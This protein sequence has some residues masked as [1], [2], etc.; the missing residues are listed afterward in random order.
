MLKIGDASTVRPRRGHGWV[1]GVALATVLA[2]SNGC[3]GSE[4]SM[5]TVGTST[6][7]AKPVL[8]LPPST[9][10]VSVAP[11]TQEPA[12][13]PTS[14]A[15]PGSLI[16]SDTAVAVDGCLGLWHTVQSS[17]VASGFV[18]ASEN[19][20]VQVACENASDLLEAD[21]SDAPIGS[22]PSRQ[23]AAVVTNISLLAVAHTF[24]FLPGAGS[25]GEQPS[26][27]LSEESRANFFVLPPSAVPAAFQGQPALP[28]TVHDIEGLV[29]DG[30]ATP[31]TTTSVPAPAA[32]DDLSA[33]LDLATAEGIL[34][35]LVQQGLPIGEQVVYTEETDP[36]ERLGRPGSYVGKA[37]WLDVRAQDGCL[38]DEIG[39]DCGGDVEVFDDQ[40]ALDDRFVYL[41]GFANESVVGGYYMW[42]VENAIVRVGFALTPTEASDY[43]RALTSLFGSAEQYGV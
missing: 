33:A 18:V 24:R 3:S 26:C 19:A 30:E 15:P 40:A 9:T 12:V 29:V 39:W 5:E 7:A 25:C 23:L 41:S 43:D 8:T 16:R 6:T 2:L 4:S 32:S 20:G 21:L 34:A 37:A 10:P 13:T 14:V 38:V 31:S 1:I 28:L 17:S 22:F 35:A 42:K 11:T 36:N 27:E